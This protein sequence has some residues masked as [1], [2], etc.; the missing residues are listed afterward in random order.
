MHAIWRAGGVSPLR[1][2]K[3]ALELQPACRRCHRNFTAHRLSVG[4]VIDERHAFAT[5]HTVN[6]SGH[7]DDLPVI[8]LGIAGRHFADFDARGPRDLCPRQCDAGNRAERV[9]GRENFVRGKYGHHA[10]QHVSRANEPTPIDRRFDRNAADVGGRLRLDRF[11]DHFADA[12][13]LIAQEQEVDQ[14]VFQRGRRLF[15]GP[16]GIGRVDRLDEQRTDSGD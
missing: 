12:A 9:L 10:T 3:H 15:D 8:D 1:I 11:E 4:R 14:T 13:P 6:L 2:R 16:C 5:A 7:R